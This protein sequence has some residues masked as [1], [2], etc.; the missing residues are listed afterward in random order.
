MDEGEEAPV[1]TLGDRIKEARTAAGLTQLELASAIGVD[2]Q[3]VSRI[4][5]NQTGEPSAVTITAIAVALKVSERWLV[6]GLDAPDTSEVPDPPHWQDF[7]NR[8]EHLSDLSDEQRDG[9][10]VFACRYAGVRS[11]TD[12]ERIAEIVR[13]GKPSAIN[14]EKRTTLEEAM[15][16]VK[17]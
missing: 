11:W 13:T 5:R 7:L 4:E 14:K 8:Y 15:R 16:N 2:P 17:P 9:I 6:R 12:L 3:T 10:R 1:A